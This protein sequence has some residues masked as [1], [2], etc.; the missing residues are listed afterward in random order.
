M[1]IAIVQSGDRHCQVAITTGQRHKQLFA[2]VYNQFS[3]FIIII[4]IN[5]II[6]EITINARP[7]PSSTNGMFVC[8]PFPAL[9]LIS[10]AL[11]YNRTSKF[12]I[13]NEAKTD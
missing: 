11:A 10:H 12:P 1:V 7:P 6:I 4:I 8:L 3:I 13:N 5:V 9:S 2:A